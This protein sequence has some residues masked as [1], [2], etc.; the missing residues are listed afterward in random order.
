MHTFTLHT[1]PP[2]VYSHEYSRFRLREEFEELNQLKIV[3]PIP[4]EELA[5]SHI[6]CVSSSTMT[7]R[8]YPIECAVPSALRC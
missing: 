4:T 2:R 3:A 1:L 7:T 6:T 5:E 8:T